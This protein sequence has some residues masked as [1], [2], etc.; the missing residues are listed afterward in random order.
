MLLT[1][2]YNNDFLN[3]VFDTFLNLPKE[4]SND[5]QIDGDT[6]KMEYEVPG[7]CKKDFTITADGSVLT[8]DGK[9]DNRTFSKKL[10]V[11][12]DFDISKTEATVKNGVLNLTIPKFEEKKRKVIEINVK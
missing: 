7:L 4:F 1:R 9:S 11:N 6:I 3:D 5:Y 12:K 10:R 8:I 2:T